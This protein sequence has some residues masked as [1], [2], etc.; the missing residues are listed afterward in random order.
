ME[1]LVRLDKLLAS[2]S[3][4]DRLFNVLGEVQDVSHRMEMLRKVQ[5][6]VVPALVDKRF[7]IFS[8]QSGHGKTH[9]ARI[10]QSMVIAELGQPAVWLNWRK[11][12]RDIKETY[13]GNGQEGEVWKQSRASVLILDDFDKAENK[14]STEQLYDILDEAMGLSG[15]PRAVVLLLNNTPAEWAEQL[16]QHGYLGEAVTSR[17]LHRSRPVWCDFSELPEWDF[18]TPGF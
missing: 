17:A 10:L 15:T 14:F 11:F 6:E 1:A 2:Y 13:N 5:E 18:G 8:G 3:A 12:L 16:K 9:M 4:E 7:A